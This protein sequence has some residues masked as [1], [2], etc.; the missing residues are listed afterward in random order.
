MN[1]NR[2]N[3]GQ[4][5]DE[6]RVLG[7]RGL[8]VPA[9]GIETLLRQSDVAKFCVADRPVWGKLDDLLERLRR[10]LPVFFSAQ[11]IAAQQERIGILGLTLEDRVRLFQGEIVRLLCLLQAAKGEAR[12]DV[13]GGQP[14]GFG[15]LLIGLSSVVGLRKG[16]SQEVMGLR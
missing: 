2:Q 1:P 15:Q 12:Q 9:G 4:H 5:V 7:Q 6:I 8:V 13:C 10:R 16:E 3:F 14:H 11:R